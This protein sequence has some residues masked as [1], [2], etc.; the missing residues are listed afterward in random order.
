MT[1][2]AYRIML[3]QDFKMAG[4]VYKIIKMLHQVQK[5]SAAA[6]PVMGTLSSMVEAGEY[7]TDFG[8]GFGPQLLPTLKYDAITA[9]IVNCVPSL[10]KDL[11]ANLNLKDLIG[12]PISLPWIESKQLNTMCEKA[13]ELQPAFLMYIVGK[14]A[15]NFNIHILKDLQNNPNSSWSKAWGSVTK[16]GAAFFCGDFMGIMTE[17][18]SET[19]KETCGSDKDCT[20]AAEGAGSSADG[21][22]DESALSIDQSNV[23]WADIWPGAKNGNLFMQSWSYVT[24]T[25]HLLEPT[26]RGIGLADIMSGSGASG[27]GPAPDT[28]EPT[29]QHALGASGNVFRLRQGLG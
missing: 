27:P 5:V 9:P 10:Q 3:T 24:G 15:E 17:L 13:G 12:L 22:I 7:E 1:G 21:N 28:V 19:V 20:T 4:R 6:M 8:I 23:S 11:T 16:N 2:N 29:G 26:D 14:V 18:T 25:R